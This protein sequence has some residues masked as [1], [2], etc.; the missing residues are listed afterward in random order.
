MALERR[1]RAHEAV[2]RHVTSAAADDVEPA[3]DR[4]FHRTRDFFRGYRDAHTG[5]TL[6]NYGSLDGGVGSIWNARQV[7]FLPSPL[8]NPPPIPQIY[9]P[10]IATQWPT[11]PH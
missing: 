11:P 5:H 3:W 8:P 7:F 9:N 2:S 1:L 10:P 6:Y 4:P